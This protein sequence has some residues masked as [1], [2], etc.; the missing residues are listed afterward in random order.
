MDTATRVQILDEVDCISHITNTTRK[1]KHPIIP[2]GIGYGYIVGMNELFK[3]GMATGL[4]E[5]RVC[6]E[7]GKY[8]H[9]SILLYYIHT[10]LQTKEQPC[11]QQC[12][13]QMMTLSQGMISEPKHR[14]H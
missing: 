11:N 7:V 8:I 5:G 9:I 4:G 1:G 6:A 14:H 12:P 3:F 10:L 13:H 2:Y